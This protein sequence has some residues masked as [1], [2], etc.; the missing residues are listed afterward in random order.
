[1]R[2]YPPVTW[3]KTSDWANYL[4]YNFS[5]LHQSS[6]VLIMWRN[7]WVI[8]RLFLTY[9]ILFGIQWGSLVTKESCKENRRH[10]LVIYRPSVFPAKT[11]SPLERH[12]YKRQLAVSWPTYL[13]CTS[14]FI[15]RWVLLF[16]AK[17]VKSDRLTW[18][19]CAVDKRNS[20]C[21]NKAW[22]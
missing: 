9:F 17:Q 5:A 20:T 18:I 13:H 3:D 15:D 8:S 14:F 16:L 22:K 1:M 7:M 19:L 4:K 21:R 2:C 10:M 12:N 6:D 11:L